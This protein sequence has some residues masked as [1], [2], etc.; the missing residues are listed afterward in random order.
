M[1]YSNCLTGVLCL[2]ALVSCASAEKKPYPE[3]PLLLSKKPVDGTDS[4]PRPDLM[5]R[6]EPRVPAMPDYLLADK[7]T[8][9]L[10]KITRRPLPADSSD[11]PAITAPATQVRPPVPAIPVRRQR[12]GASPARF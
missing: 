5:A 6:A 3:H 2:V 8:R 11:L 1:V 4:R 10:E 9:N 7:Q 12:E